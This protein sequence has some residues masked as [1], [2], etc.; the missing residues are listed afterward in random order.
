MSVSRRP[1]E[2]ARPEL[3]VTP[4]VDVVLVLLIVFMVVAPRLEHDV[5]VELPGVLNPD[6]VA[7]A[8]LEPIVVTIDA[9]GALHL[10]GRPW[11]PEEAFGALARLHADAPDRALA[12]RADGAT[13]YGRVRAVAAEARR[14]G[15]AGVTLLVGERHRD[16]PDGGES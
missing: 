16:H 9:D 14:L 6:P 11:S 12:I 8:A 1:V 4:L 15:F 7:R 10:A 2:G 5:P 3:N 13:A